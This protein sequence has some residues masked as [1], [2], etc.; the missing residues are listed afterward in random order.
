MA[1]LDREQLEALRAQVEEDYRLD[2]AAIE[3][4]QRRFISSG[5][6]I[7]GNSISGA[8]APAPSQQSWN[9]GPASNVR[10]EPMPSYEPV[11]NPQP[12][13]VMTS[14]RSIFSSQRSR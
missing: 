2:L 11:P 9:P 13:E 6:S 1:S 3:R 12:D 10:E 8:S 14:I 4:L 5:S 7:S